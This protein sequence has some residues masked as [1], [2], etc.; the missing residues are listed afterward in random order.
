M[1]ILTRKRSQTIQIGD[2]I[3]I[4]VIRTGR[5]TVKLGIEAPSDV[6]LLRGELAPQNGV[7]DTAC[8]SADAETSRARQEAGTAGENQS[9]H[10][11]PHG[12]GSSISTDFQLDFQSASCAPQNDSENSADILALDQ[13]DEESPSAV[14]D[15]Y[16]HPHIA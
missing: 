13:A 12:R 16:P 9:S 14:S 7:H 10:P 4:K 6:R 3:L 15:Q 1:L 2:D 8:E 11:L 5:N